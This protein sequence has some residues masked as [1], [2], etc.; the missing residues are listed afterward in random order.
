M[1]EPDSQRQR[2]ADVARRH[3][4]VG[5]AALA[6]FV[7]LGAVL[8]ALHAFKVAGYL[9]AEHETRRLML[10]LAHAHGTLLSILNIVFGLTAK[11][12]P[13]AC[14]ALSSAAMFVS[15][16]LVPLG[17]GLG[18]ISARGGDPGALVLL[19]PPGALSLF[20]GLLLTARRLRATDD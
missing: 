20:A 8:E 18:G 11:A 6:F 10:R 5:F 17:F 16:A 19:V 7:L 13:R 3:L 15:L 9:D 14:T 1:N 4:R 12:Y 2:A